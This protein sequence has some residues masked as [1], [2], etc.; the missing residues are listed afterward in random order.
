MWVCNSQRNMKLH[1][2]VGL[3]SVTSSY[4]PFDVFYQHRPPELQE[5]SGPDCEDTF[6]PEVIVSLFN[7]SKLPRLWDHELI[8]PMRL[9][10]P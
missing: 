10:M 3:T 9:V 7:Q 1:C 4:I 5:Q 8:L 2:L 6:V